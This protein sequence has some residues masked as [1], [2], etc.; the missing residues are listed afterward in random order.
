[1]SLRILILSQ[2]RQNVSELTRQVDSL[3]PSERKKR[4]MFQLCCV[5]DVEKTTKGGDERTKLMAIIESRCCCYCCC[6][7]YKCKE[8]ERKKRGK[9]RFQL[10]FNVHLAMGRVLKCTVRVRGDLCYFFIIVHF[11]H[12]VRAH[13][14]DC[15]HFQEQ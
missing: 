3:E 1:M 14:T 4:K 9:L 7:C 13:Y 11:A 10:I 5:V 12:R 15:Y 8:S 6:C 2:R